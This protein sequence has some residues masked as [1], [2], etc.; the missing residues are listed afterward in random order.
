MGQRLIVTENEK[1]HISKMYGLINEQPLSGSYNMNPKSLIGKTVN[2]YR[3]TENKQI[4]PAFSQVK[5]ISVED[6][7][8]GVIR[9]DINNSNGMELKS[10]LMMATDD[11]K[12]LTLQEM[13]N[14]LNLDLE[15][16]IKYNCDNSDF[17]IDGG[18]FKGVD[19]KIPKPVNPSRRSEWSV[20]VNTFLKVLGL[21][22]DTTIKNKPLSEML[23][24]I[25]C[26]KSRS[27]E[28]VPKADFASTNTGNSSVA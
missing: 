25:Y 20:T 27:G 21:G 10:D 18:H 12:T 7:R 3:D 13:Q 15:V 1:N 22:A 24:N 23:D 28:G 5:I 16:R 6:Y 17:T 9:F 8:Q 11:S 26:S 2:F 19:G 4:I 14:W